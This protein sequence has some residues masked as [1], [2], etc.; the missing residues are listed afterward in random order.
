MSHSR[1]KTN[2][3][4]AVIGSTLLI[5]AA[6]TSDDP[7]ALL[8]AL[9]K[10]EKA[11]QTKREDELKTFRYEAQRQAARRPTQEMHSKHQNNHQ[12]HQPSPGFRNK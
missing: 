1:K 3:A 6:M 12:I 2:T 7:K 5:A 11:H 8:T 9:E 10:E 4:T